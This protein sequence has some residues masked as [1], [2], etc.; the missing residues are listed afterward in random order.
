MFERRRSA[1]NV[2]CPECGSQTQVIRSRSGVQQLAGHRKPA[3][4]LLVTES[5]IAVDIAVICPGSFALITEV[6]P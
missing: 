3:Q 6:A 4:R 2:T 1:V 5:A